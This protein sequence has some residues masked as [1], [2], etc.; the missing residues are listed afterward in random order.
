MHLLSS[1]ATSTAAL[2]LIQSSNRSPHHKKH[3]QPLLCWQVNQ[4]NVWDPGLCPQCIG[5]AAIPGCFKLPTPLS[6]PFRDRDSTSFLGSPFQHL[7]TILVKVFFLIYNLNCLWHNLRHFPPVPSLVTWEQ[8]NAPEPLV[9]LGHSTEAKF[10]SAGDIY[11]LLR[12]VQSNLSQL[13]VSSPL[14]WLYLTFVCN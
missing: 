1:S 8:M 6:N 9:M 3:T 14:V 2:C 13:R 12:Q 7:T 4:A 5:F 10:V 11:P